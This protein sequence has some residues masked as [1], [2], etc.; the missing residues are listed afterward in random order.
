MCE[1]LTQRIRTRRT[2]S[3]TDVSDLE[4]QA[5]LHTIEEGPVTSPAIMSFDVQPDI[6]V[7]PQHVRD[8]TFYTISRS[9]DSLGEFLKRPI[10]VV[11][12][13]WVIGTDVTTSFDVYNAFLNNPRVSNRLAN[14]GFVAGNMCIKIVTNG[15]PFYYGKLIAGIYHYPDYD[16][17]TVGAISTTQ[18]SQL[19]HVSIDANGGMAGCLNVPLYNPN[20]AIS[21]S[22]VRRFP[23]FRLILR[24]IAPLRST[25]NSTQPLSFTVFA[26]FDDVQ[27]FGPTGFLPVG[28]TPQAGEIE[29]PTLSQAATAC[30]DIVSKTVAPPSFSPYVKAS[31][32]VLRGVGKMASVFGFSMP[33]KFEQGRKVLPSPYADMALTSG[34][35]VNYKL[36]LDFKN[37]VTIDPAV[38]GLGNEDEMLISKIASKES[39]LTTFTWLSSQLQ[40]AV[41][42]RSVVTPSLC[43][44]N[45]TG[46]IPSA[47][48]R[49]FLT[50]AAHVS[51][52]FRYWRGSMKFRFEV[53]ASAFHRGKI[54]IFYDPLGPI[55]SNNNIDWARSDNVTYSYVLDLA[56]ERE[57]TMVVGWNQSRNFKRTNDPDTPMF[58]A[59]INLNLDSPNYRQ[60]YNGGIGL[61][62]VTPLVST[63]NATSADVLV[64]VYVSMTDDFQVAVPDDSVMKRYTLGQWFLGVAAPAFDLNDL[65]LPAVVPPGLTIANAP[66]AV[67][68]T[69]VTEVQHTTAKDIPPGLS[70]LEPQAGQDNLVSLSGLDPIVAPDLMLDNSMTQV[71]V[72]DKLNLIHFGEAVT[73]LREVIKR[74]CLT[75]TFASDPLPSG[76]SVYFRQWFDVFPRTCGVFLARGGLPDS[77]GNA[78]QYA[79]PSNLLAW[80]SPAFLMYRGSLRGKIYV[81][82]LADGVPDANVREIVVSREHN[83]SEK[84]YGFYISSATDFPNI[85]RWTTKDMY[86]SDGGTCGIA[87]N[88]SINSTVIPYE[89]PFNSEFRWSFA[90]QRYRASSATD[91]ATNHRQYINVTVATSKASGNLTRIM[92]K[93]FT[94]AGDDFSFHKYQCAPCALKYLPRAA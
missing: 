11:D 34:A 9:D 87:M 18:C 29:Q 23:P 25:N 10:R 68:A 19:Q 69:P 79:N 57:Y 38:V 27:L 46:T 94:A 63:Q 71:D 16:D 21:L 49:A 64:A 72:A 41:V 48:N 36:A 62:V 84:T 61:S 14:Y 54:R 53:I 20:S 40:D 65:I 15:S 66:A 13:N 55:N 56:K 43:T 45:R 24:T 77:N 8:D 30:A 75:E 59:D 42:W 51:M 78:S 92:I 2:S 85:G 93:Q 91:G 82:P 90:Q 35:D 67:Q 47:P 70:F 32:M 89:I 58:S 33:T 80:F 22:G 26:W 5:A 3:E 7:I 1:R 81:F 83:P 37:E 86:D 44:F 50:P 12:Y 73:S 28:L 60:Y 31:E 6:E 4:P 76:K 74:Y 17:A 88:N 39:Y 52:P